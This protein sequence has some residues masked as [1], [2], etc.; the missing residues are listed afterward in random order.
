MN[1]GLSAWTFEPKHGTAVASQASRD[2]E[3]LDILATQHRS[4]TIC[5]IVCD[6]FAIESSGLA[7]PTRRSIAEQVELRIEHTSG[8]TIPVRTTSTASS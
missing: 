1:K 3:E 4:Y 2:L 5:I 8:V 7:I 6:A